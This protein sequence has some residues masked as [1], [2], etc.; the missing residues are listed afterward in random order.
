V[1][2]PLPKLKK[3]GQ[4]F[5]ADERVARK[6]VSAADITPG[7][8][9]LEVGPGDGAI[10]RILVGEGA[11]VLAVEIDPGRAA[12]LAGELGNPP[13]LTVLSGDFL[14]KSVSEWLAQARLPGPVVLVGNLPYNAATPIVSRAIEERISVSRLIVTVQKEVAQRF[15]ARPGSPAY[16]YLSVRTALFAS[17]EILFDLAPG[18]F[19]PPPKVTSSVLRLVPREP[20]LAGAALERT[21]LLASRA[22]R[23][24]R[25]TLPNALA[26][27]GGREKWVRALASLSHL[28]TARAEELSPEEFVS[29]GE[30][31]N[32]RH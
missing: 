9:V 21:L 14:D 28:P 10:T 22:F 27:L 17:G 16:G 31:A 11:V 12:R 26:S 23:A 24:R 19:R 7:Q 18:A 1:G 32:E 2:L 6:I 15:L 13:N 3:W 29:L 5:L 20:P 8:A 25:K 4:H 30:R